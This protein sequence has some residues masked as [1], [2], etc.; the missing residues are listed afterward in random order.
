MMAER[1]T[2][3]KCEALKN[4]GLTQPFQWCGGQARK[5][6]RK[7]KTRMQAERGNKLVSHTQVLA[8][9]WHKAALSRQHTTRR[10]V[11]GAKPAAELNESDNTIDWSWRWPVTGVPQTSPLDPKK[12]V[13]AG[14]RGAKEPP[15]NTTFTRCGCLGR[16]RNAT[17]EQM[18]LHKGENKQETTCRRF[19]YSHTSCKINPPQKN[20]TW[21]LPFL[22]LRPLLKI[23]SGGIF[24]EN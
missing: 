14:V 2:P 7:K 23:P 5:E 13:R 4:V 16:A 6:L 19:C 15:R 24:A 8:E 22:V 17:G 3:S 21:G 12:V 20:K 9:P 18:V 1:K 10:G 11:P